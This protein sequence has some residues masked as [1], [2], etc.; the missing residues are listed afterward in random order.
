MKSIQFYPAPDPVIEGA[1]VRGSGGG[2][3]KGSTVG[4][5]EAAMVRGGKLVRMISAEAFWK[6]YDEEQAKKK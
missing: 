4:P 6:L 3:G 5:G 1:T 2:P